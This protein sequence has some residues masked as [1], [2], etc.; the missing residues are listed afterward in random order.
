VFSVVLAAYLAGIGLGSLS[1]SALSKRIPNQ[2]YLLAALYAVV[3]LGVLVSMVAFP[4]IARFF[5]DLVASGTIASWQSY[6]VTIGLL[7]WLCMLPAT[8]AMGAALPLLIGASSLARNSAESNADKS[9][10]QAADPRAEPRDKKRARIAGRLYA[11][12]IAGGVLGSLAATFILMPMLGLERALAA[13]GTLYFALALLVAL[14][15][16]VKRTRRF[17][18]A[19]AIFAL[20]TALTASLTVANA[21]PVLAPERG[22]TRQQIFAEDGPSASIV[23]AEV[24]KVWGVSVRSLKVNNFYGLNITSPPTVAM[25]Y[26]LGHLPLLLHPR[27]K[28]ALLIGFATGNTLAA[29]AEHRLARLDCVEL[30]AKLFALAPYFKAVNHAVY[31]QKRVH[32]FAQDGR[33]FVRRAGPSYDVVIGDLYLPRNPG[34]G[35]L[36]SRAHFA[37]I[38]RR[39]SQNGLFVAWLPLW[40]LSPWEVGVIAKTFLSVFPK[41]DAWLGNARQQRPVLGLVGYKSRFFKTSESAL[42]SRLLEVVKRSMRRT[43]G[44][45]REISLMASGARRVLT[46]AQLA[47]WAANK[48][49]NTLDHPIIEYS[50]PR[51]LTRY[52]LRNRSPA[53]DNLQMILS[54]QKAT[55]D[56]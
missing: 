6:I 54:L 18:R 8:L 27:P 19:G 53:R 37:A 28:R 45:R 49:Q 46:S 52:Q 2:R 51:T 23:I 5:Y 7:T 17:S 16:A 1:L 13:C 29:M 20:A 32:L 12:N 10:D 39:L 50:A 30:H 43:Y 48:P 41:A 14:T 55:H 22:D 47:R 25:Q 36:Y 40:Q 56:P 33:H 9:T 44:A 31:A 26:R 15:G 35:A 38:D 42:G 3:G 21:L 34:V 4:H 11:L 24:A